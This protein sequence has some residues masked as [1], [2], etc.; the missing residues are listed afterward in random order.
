MENPDTTSDFTT[1]MRDKYSPES[2]SQAAPSETAKP[3][4]KTKTST[5]EHFTDGLVPSQFKLPSDLVASLKLHSIASG[6]S[7]SEIVLDCL[8]SE[9]MIAK[10]WISTKRAA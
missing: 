10:A 8:T 7:M 9:E 2:D 6:R 3:K 5:R 1:R 4:A